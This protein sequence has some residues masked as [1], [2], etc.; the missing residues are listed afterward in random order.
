MREVTAIIRIPCFYQRK[1]VPSRSLTGHPATAPAII[2]ELTSADCKIPYSI[3]PFPRVKLPGCAS[4]HYRLR[5]S[6]P[7]FPAT[8][9]HSVLNP[10]S[11]D[12]HLA[13]VSCAKWH[14][15]LALLGTMRC[16]R[17][18][19]GDA[20]GGGED[21]RKERTQVA[22][23]VSDDLRKAERWEQEGPIRAQKTGAFGK[24]SKKSRPTFL[25][26]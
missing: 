15:R 8:H 24:L 1:H 5:F 9:C 26:L 3:S 17:R 11:R 4:R 13:T 25:H 10:C 19:K 21:L 16:A 7:A 22:H 14:H 18:H 2:P 12:A 20:Q 23:G 6:R